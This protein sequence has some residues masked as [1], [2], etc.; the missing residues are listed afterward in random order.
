MIIN[1]LFQSNLSWQVML[2]LMPSLYFVVWLSMRSTK[3]QNI[4]CPQEQLMQLG[5]ESSGS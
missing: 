1:R 5:V 3:Q 4:L 2:M